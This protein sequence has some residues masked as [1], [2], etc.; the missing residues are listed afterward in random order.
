MQTAGEAE[1]NDGPSGGVR[2]KGG[3]VTIYISVAV[4]GMWRVG[5]VRERGYRRLPVH[6]PIIC[7]CRGR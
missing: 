6:P 4:V 5:L 1:K 3:S 2:T 7:S